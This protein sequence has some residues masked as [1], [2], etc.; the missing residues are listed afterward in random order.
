MPAVPYSWAVQLTLSH[1][2]CQG[3]P[4]GRNKRLWRTKIK[5]RL[6]RLQRFLLISRGPQ[7]VPSSGM[8]KRNPTCVRSRLTV[9]SGGREG[10]SYDNVSPLLPLLFSSLS[11][12]QQQQQQKT[13]PAPKSVPNPSNATV[14]PG[15]DGL[16]SHFIEVFLDLF[17]F[18]YGRN[19]IFFVFAT[20]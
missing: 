4:K 1:A 12:C 19:P 2:H 3:R 13:K 11:S 15:E 20:M 14:A 6:G 8:F 16:R 5:F 17:F 7:S 9:S 18:T 10:V